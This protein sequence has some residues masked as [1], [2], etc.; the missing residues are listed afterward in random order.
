MIPLIRIYQG[1]H[2]IKAKVPIV[3]GKVPRYLA[4]KVL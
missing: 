4:S 2:T 1:Y 3:E